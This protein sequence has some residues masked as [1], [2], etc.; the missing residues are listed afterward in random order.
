MGYVFVISPLAFLFSPPSS[1]PYTPSPT[2]PLSSIFQIV[3]MKPTTLIVPVVVP[4]LG[5]LASVN[6]GPVAYGVCQTGC[7]AL[8]CACYGAAGLTFGTV[9]AAAGA[10]AAAI[11]CNTAFGTCSAKC[12]A[13]FWL[14]TP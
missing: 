7:S 1:K 11:A 10:P 5:F 13:A 6:A 3:E 8:V 2:A 14:P 4:V 9:V 12:A